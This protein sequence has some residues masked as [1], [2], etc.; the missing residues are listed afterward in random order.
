MLVWVPDETIEFVIMDA[1]RGV[2]L[3]AD[4]PS[5][6]RGRL[7]LTKLEEDQRRLLAKAVMEKLRQSHWRIVRP[8]IRPHG[9]PDFTWKG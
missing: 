2:R 9:R 1:M 4:P 6:R 8:E 5:R 3:P 7:Q